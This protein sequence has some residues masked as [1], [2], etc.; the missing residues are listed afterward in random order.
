MTQPG[1]LSA[2]AWVQPGVI[3][4]QHSYNPW[5]T[6]GGRLAR[7]ST[8]DGAR[9]LQDLRYTYDAMGNVLTLKDYWNNN[10]GPQTQTFTYDTLD[11]LTS[12]QAFGGLF[13]TYTLEIY[14][15]NATS[16][17]L[18]TKA[19]L[20]YTYGDANHAHA[21]TSLSN[22]NTYQYDPNGNMSFRQVGGQTYNLTHDAEN[23]LI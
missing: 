9:L 4:T 15:Y 19:G 8:T 10:G 14:T 20:S 12:A 23:R 5:N 16:G 6:Q 11:R 7:L 18:S 17:N 22:G 2:T 21:V 1:V 13:G 3:V